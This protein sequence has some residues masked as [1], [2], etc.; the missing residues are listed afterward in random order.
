MFR[1]FF[2]TSDGHNPS[3]FSSS[4]PLS[5]PAWSNNR[6]ISSGLWSS[7]SRSS[8]A[9]SGPHSFASNFDKPSSQKNPCKRVH[10]WTLS[11]LYCIHIS[12]AATSCIFTAPPVHTFPPICARFGLIA[13]VAK[14]PTEFRPCVSSGPNQ[15]PRSRHHDAYDYDIR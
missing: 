5:F 7:S 9:F 14:Q 1:V 3:L 6:F 8:L 11:P 10:V 12:R 2:L 15:K 4:F 13:R